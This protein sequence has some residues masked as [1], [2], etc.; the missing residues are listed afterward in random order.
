MLHS[1]NGGYLMNVQFSLSCRFLASGLHPSTCTTKWVQHTQGIFS[2]SGFTNPNNRD[3]SKRSYDGGYQLSK[4][5]Q[6]FSIWLW[7][8]SHERGGVCS[9]WPITDMD[10]STVSRAAHFTKEEHTI[11]DKYEEVKHIIQTNSNTVKAAKCRK[12]L[13]KEKKIADVKP[14]VNVC[15]L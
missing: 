6:G 9:I 2:L 10:K 1:T 15:L 8:C 3:P 14:K 12:K 5:T 4:S 13:A 7:A 11:M